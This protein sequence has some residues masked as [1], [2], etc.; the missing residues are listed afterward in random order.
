MIRIEEMLT[1]PNNS[2]QFK[3]MPKMNRHV[4]TTIAKYYRLN[5]Y[6][7]DYEPKRYVSLVKNIDSHVPMISLSSCIN[8]TINT[9]NNN[10][11]NNNNNNMTMSSSPAS[12]AIL[13]QNQVVMQL[14][15]PLPIIYI[16][17]NDAIGGYA[18]NSM[19]LPGCEMRPIGFDNNSNSSNSNAYAVYC[20]A[21]IVW[22]LSTVLTTPRNTN[23]NNSTTNTTANT[24]SNS[25]NNTTAASN[26]SNNNNSVNQS[27]CQFTKSYCKYKSIKAYGPCSVSYYLLF[28]IITLYSYA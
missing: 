21:D 5:A 13:L 23:T 10:N 3:P 16:T 25:D 22:L 11:N 4:I 26:S 2:V 8:N 9:S 6:E 24:T 17:L 14:N 28:I 15:A 1:S 18:G 7:Y 27:I 20:V 12:V 19:T